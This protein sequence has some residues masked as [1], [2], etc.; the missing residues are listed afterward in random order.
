M[1]CILFTLSHSDDNFFIKKDQH[2]YFIDHV[3][4]VINYTK[5]HDNTLNEKV[6][7]Y[8]KDKFI[9]DSVKERLK[10][11]EKNATNIYEKLLY[12]TILIDYENLKKKYTDNSGKS[13][14]VDGTGSTLTLDPTFSA[15]EV[16]NENQI[17]G[18]GT[19]SI[20]TLDP[21]LSAA[22]VI[23]E[24]QNRNLNNFL[25]NQANKKIIDKNLE[26]EKAIM[27][28]MPNTTKFNINGE[29]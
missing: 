25:L 10:C 27:T 9:V 6:I 18:S 12:E 11:E 26:I 1:I 19:I 15:A 21:S 7:Q 4:F 28:N 14:W 8:L 24:N 13:F 2:E 17:G 20:L 29:L 23:N 5:K 22:K 16:I 3:V